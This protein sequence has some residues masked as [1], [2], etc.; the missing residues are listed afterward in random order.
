MGA[1][2]VLS[3]KTRQL[4]NVARPGLR[5]QLYPC[6]PQGTAA[7]RVALSLN[8]ACT[9]LINTISTISAI[10]AT[11]AVSTNTITNIS[12]SH[13]SQQLITNNTQ[14][15]SHIQCQIERLALH[16]EPSRQPPT[17]ST[18]QLHTIG[19]GVCLAPYRPSL[20]G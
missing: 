18:I 15:T 7:A 17:L 11:G 2:E 19:N 3:I 12:C 14:H 6:A 10:G 20:Q 9:N 13:A 5:R 8:Q 16:P 1:T 4:V